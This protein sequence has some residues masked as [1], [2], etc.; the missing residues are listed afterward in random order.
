MNN[1]CEKELLKEEIKKLK[2]RKSEMRERI[3]EIELLDRLKEKER[4]DIVSKLKNKELL[5]YVFPYYDQVC[6]DYRT[7]TGKVCLR[8]WKQMPHDFTAIR[9]LA[10]TITNYTIFSRRKDNFVEQSIQ[11]RNLNQLDDTELQLVVDCTDEIIAVLCKYKMLCKKH[12]NRDNSE[13]VVGKD[14]L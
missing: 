12:Q 13:F 1:E 7:M 14:E 10:K 4:C 9:N 8:R 2:E 11:R 5:N 3:K 6:R